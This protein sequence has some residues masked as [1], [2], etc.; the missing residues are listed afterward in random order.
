[1]KDQLEFGEIE[2]PGIEDLE[3]AEED[4]SGAYGWDELLDDDAQAVPEEF[5]NPSGI[6]RGDCDTDDA[7]D[8]ESC[9]LESTAQ[10]EDQVLEET[11][12]GAGIWGFEG[13]EVGGG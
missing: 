12:P 10:T 13:E 2:G 8:D 7:I 6:A 4:R 5:E 3:D 11:K 9:D 1:M